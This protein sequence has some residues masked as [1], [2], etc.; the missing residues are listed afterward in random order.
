VKVSEA[1]ARYFRAFNYD[2]V[3]CASANPDDAHRAWDIHQGLFRPYVRVPID[4]QVTCVVGANESGKS[5]LLTILRQ[6]LLAQSR[7][8]S[9]FCRYS[10]AFRVDDVLRLPHLGV[11]LDGIT[12]SDIEALANLGITATTGSTVRV[13]Q[14][15]SQLVDL[16]IDDSDAPI[17]VEAGALRPL[18]PSVVEIDPELRLPDAVPLDFLVNT[19]SGAET[20]IVTSSATAAIADVL[21][22][23][24]S[25]A[26]L[27]ANRFQ[28][29]IT[30]FREF[31]LDPST[32]AQYSLA[33]DLLTT[34]GGVD[35]STFETL[36]SINSRQDKRGFVGA[37]ETQI[38]EQLV[39]TLN[40]SSWW[41]QDKAFRVSVRIREFE[42][43][44]MLT[45]RTGYEYAFDERSSGLRYFLS[46]LIQYFSFLKGPL[47]SGR[48]EVLLM[49]EPDA[50]LSNAAQQD[51][52]R[53][54]QHFADGGTEKAQQVVYVT[55]SPFLIDKNR[56]E[57]VRVLDKGVGD[58]G[59][60]IVKDVS[61]N[62]FEPLRSAFGS[63]VAETVYIGTCNIILE[64]A[65]DHIYL[66]NASRVLLRRGTPEGGFLDLNEVT[67]VPAG[68]ASH[69][70]YLTFL[71]RGRDAHQPA[72]VAF[73][74]GDPE[75][76]A[77]AQSL[78]ELTIEGAKT[79]PDRFVVELNS[80]IPGLDTQRP[81]GPTCI[82]DLVPPELLAQA[83]D[84]YARR[85][86]LPTPGLSAEAIVGEM[87]ETEDSYTAVQS[88]L[89]AA[90]SDLRL[91][92]VPLSLHVAEIVASSSSPD[93][94]API[95]LLLAN[96]EH[97]CRYLTALQSDAVSERVNREVLGRTRRA[98]RSFL[99]E[100]PTGC[101]KAKLRFL[102]DEIERGLDDTFESLAIRNEIG[103]LR[104]RAQL[105]SDDHVDVQEY[106]QIREQLGRLHEAGLVA[107]QE[108]GGS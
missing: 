10:E 74:D 83:C 66:A 3:R 90:G 58:Q 88:A 72:V 22:N 68:S 71:A 65:S 18:L 86:G 41:T 25:N 80:G 14:Q 44:L 108:G 39:E 33:Y 53:L 77:K 1:Y 92:K 27:M 6:A 104:F 95:E 97:L 51:L 36:R 49:D 59:T 89:T 48:D 26:N 16:Y 94:D 43:S 91:D 7:D 69:V 13:F 20:H 101:T 99:R 34:C 37:L 63:F 60:R 4:D 62:H 61:R 78:R 15:D 12:G 28:E 103:N 57:R 50:Y 29:L 11:A 40:L 64:G 81:G 85:L 73:F 54:F 84:A 46:Y 42:I 47:R 87:S 24:P 93:T 55:H 67:L 106:G 82:E 23:L 45:D 52:L 19:A 100:N 31:S 102:F 30:S 32:A 76:H 107:S 56:P 2:H 9:D 70:C 98:V 8:V 17:T 96:F 105:D 38:N 21:R 5:Q 35:P 75:G 79:I